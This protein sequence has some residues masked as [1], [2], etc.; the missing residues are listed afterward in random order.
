MTKNDT[1]I[2]YVKLNK[3]MYGCIRSARLFYNNLSG[4]LV[5]IGFEINPYDM[6]VANKIMTDTQCTITCGRPENV[7]QR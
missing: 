5:T 1:T 4:T 2:I 6:C 3:A 7:T